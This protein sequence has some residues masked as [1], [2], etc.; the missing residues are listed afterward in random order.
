MATKRGRVMTYLEGLLPIKSHGFANS[1]G[2]LKT[3]IHYHNAFG[4]VVTFPLIKP[5]NPSITW[6]C[7]VK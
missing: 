4:L 3:N 6:P 2:K 5:Y 1:R 7:E